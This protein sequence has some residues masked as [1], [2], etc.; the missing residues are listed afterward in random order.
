MFEGVGDIL[1][2][3]QRID[4]MGF[5]NGEERESRNNFTNTMR[6]VV[7]WYGNERGS[8]YEGSPEVWYQGSEYWLIAVD[9]SGGET[10]LD[11]KIFW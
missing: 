6:G 10:E 7:I 5:Q 2:Y 11:G 4:D 1:R 3:S 8:H 9:R